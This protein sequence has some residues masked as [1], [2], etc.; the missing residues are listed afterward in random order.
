MDPGTDS[1]VAVLITT[2]REHAEK[3]AALLIESR[4]A[5]CVNIVSEISSLYRWKGSVVNDK[6]SLL[7]AKTSQSKFAHLREITRANH[8]YTVPE[9]IALPVVFADEDYA[10][11]VREETSTMSLGPGEI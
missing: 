3:L 6:E 5:A 1:I 11:W 8:P 10:S 4:S 2:P 9:I 7:I